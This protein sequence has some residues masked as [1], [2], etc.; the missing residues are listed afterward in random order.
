[1]ALTLFGAVTA[2]AAPPGDERE[3]NRPV[4]RAAAL[5]GETDADRWLMTLPD[6]IRIALDNSGIVCVVYGRLPPG[7]VTE[8]D[9]RD[10]EAFLGY[11]P[12]YVAPLGFAERPLERTPIT[13]PFMIHR[14]NADTPP[15]RF[16]AEDMALVRSVEQ[17]YWVVAAQR[18][19]V[20]CGEQVVMTAAD[21]IKKEQAEPTGCSGCNVYLVDATIRFAQFEKDMKAR[22]AKL[23]DA[24]RRLRLLLGLPAS[25]GRHIVA[26]TPPID[27]AVACDPRN[28]GPAVDAGY[29]QYQQAKQHRLD[30]ARRLAA[31]KAWYDE[32]R[33]TI[34]RY[35]DIISQH[36]EAV[37]A[38]A[39]RAS[40]YN[41]AIAAM[42]EA[43]GTLLA[44]RFILVIDQPLR[45]PKNW[46][47]GPDEPGDSIKKASPQPGK[48][49]EP[50]P[51]W[52][53]PPAAT[54]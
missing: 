36:A 27:Q 46:V 12:Y 8:E 40:E 35:F 31:N 3:T 54:R 22:T 47:A 48:V 37:A 26:V 10:P 42:G 4:L 15:E 7:T 20:A 29:R 28:R 45:T 16:R 39:D 13:G 25:D 34:T 14:V 50:K 23:A 32:G 24:D 49:N 1:L 53:E 38:E 33:I 51:S 41:A 43:K 9:R 6:A 52:G 17:Q 30:A 18:M 5:A 44:D 21:L 2:H 11:L 19:R